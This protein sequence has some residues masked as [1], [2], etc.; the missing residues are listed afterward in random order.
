[1][2]ACWRGFAY[3]EAQLLCALTPATLGDMLAIVAHDDVAAVDGVLGNIE[4][5]A[6]ADLLGHGNGDSTSALA[7]WGGLQNASVSTQNT[8]H[9]THGGRHDDNDSGDGDVD[10]VK[11]REEGAGAN[12]VRNN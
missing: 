7:G 5:T 4:D 6:E 2:S 1:M 9:K 8:A 10:A 11:K 3:T 12:K